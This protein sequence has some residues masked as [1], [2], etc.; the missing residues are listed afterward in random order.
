MILYPIRGESGTKITPNRVD[1]QAIPTHMG[2]FFCNSTMSDPEAIARGERLT[3]FAKHRYGSARR[4]ALTCNI[5]ENSLR[6]Y[7]TGERPIPVEVLAIV[8]AAGGSADWVITGKGTM[9]ADTSEVDSMPITINQ[10]R[11]ILRQT[12]M[13]GKSPSAPLAV[14]PIDYRIQ[15]AAAYHG[16]V[17]EAKTGEEKRPQE[18]KDPVTI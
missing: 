1:F 11:E 6:R 17:S 5:P 7:C 15:H 13:A 2:C 18:G 12:V 16:M 9:V 10:L 4:M 8:V 3:A 14:A